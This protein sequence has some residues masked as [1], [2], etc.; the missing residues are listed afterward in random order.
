MSI[1]EREA[2]VKIQEGSNRTDVNH[3]TQ[4]EVNQNTRDHS[5]SSD[6]Q[7]RQRHINDKFARAPTLQADEPNPPMIPGRKESFII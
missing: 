5:D 7:S 2:N 1:T 4:E 6:T 3:D